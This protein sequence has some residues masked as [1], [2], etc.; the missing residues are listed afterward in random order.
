MSISIQHVLSSFQG[1]L[2]LNLCILR[3]IYGV[4]HFELVPRADA[5]LSCNQLDGVT[6]APGAD[7]HGW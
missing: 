2:S 3:E 4:R 1:S 5:M 7:L 6:V